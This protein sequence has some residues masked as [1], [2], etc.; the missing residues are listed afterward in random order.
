[1]FRFTDNPCKTCYGEVFGEPF[2][3]TRDHDLLEFLLSSHKLINKSED[4]RFLEPW[5]GHG[6]ITSNGLYTGTKDL[7]DIIFEFGV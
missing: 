2:V 1:M 7:N 4:Y 5:L 6:L 3:L